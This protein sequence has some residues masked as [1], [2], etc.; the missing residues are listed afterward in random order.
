MKVSEIKKRGKCAGTEP[1]GIRSDDLK[2]RSG[3]GMLDR[4]AESRTLKL[5][6]NES[7]LVQ[8][9]EGRDQ[10]TKVSVVMPTWNR[11]FVIPRAVDSV[12]K[13]RYQNYELLI[14]D[15]GSSDGTEG[16]VKTHYGGDRR[17]RYFKNPHGGVSSARN[18]ALG[19]A[20]GSLVAY[21]DTDNVWSENYL[22][23]MVNSF[24][25]HPEA[26]T[27]YCGVRIID[28]VYNSDF[29]RMKPYDRES[30]L[31]RNYI[32]VNVFMHRT[33][34]LK[35]LKGFDEGLTALE[36]WEFIIRYTEEKP[37]FVLECC[38]VDYYLEK[39]FEHLSLTGDLEKNFKKIR[40]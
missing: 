26:D 27:M 16:L 15:D 18:V 14:S 9:Y 22:L 20:T 33:I 7:K 4:L 17:I 24:T 37:P 31:L 3:E 40:R 6:V 35:R 32:D 5:R 8:E 13:Q 39:E 19:Q 21:L 1:A 38:L 28:Q 10:A 11:A 30:L 2:I 29:I 23:L 36:D 34:L 12:L 25:E